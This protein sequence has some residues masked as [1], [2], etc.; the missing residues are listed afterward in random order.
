MTTPSLPTGRRRDSAVELSRIRAGSSVPQAFEGL[1]LGQ[2][3]RGGGTVTGDIVGFHRNGF[4]Q[5]R[6]KVFERFRQVDV[7]RDGHAVVGDQRAAECLVQHHVATTW[8]EGDLDGIG[9][10][11]DAGLQVL[12]R[13]LIKSNEFCHSGLLLLTFR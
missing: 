8:A 6:T 4:H 2:Q 10:R 9:E 5:L 12:T 11:V 13:L 1:R 7:T 3:R